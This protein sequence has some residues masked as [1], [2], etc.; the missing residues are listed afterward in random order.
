[1][2]H[3]PE[4]S[5]GILRPH[6]RHLDTVNDHNALTSTGR[7]A[8]VGSPAS[9]TSARANSA[10]AVSGRHG[11]ILVDEVLEPAFVA[12]VNLGS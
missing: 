10:I 7:D 12:L 8:A 6:Q 1:M 5:G 4:A 11:A 2:P 3:P 9:S